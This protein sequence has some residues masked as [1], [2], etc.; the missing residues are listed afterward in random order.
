MLIPT[1][2]GLHHSTNPTYPSLITHNYRRSQVSL[3]TP[4]LF[5]CQETGVIYCLIPR[6]VRYRERNYVTFLTEGD[7]GKPYLTVPRRWVSLP[8]SIRIWEFVLQHYH[9]SVTPPLEVR[10]NPKPSPEKVLSVL[11][12]DRAYPNWEWDSL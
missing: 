12:G 5:R 3:N 6:A 1:F 8:I 11:K 4:L 7:V 2:T 9:P 10:P